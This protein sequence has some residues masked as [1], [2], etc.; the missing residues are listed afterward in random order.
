MDGRPALGGPA[1][2]GDTQGGKQS[3]DYQRSR[4][5]GGWGQPGSLEGID[6]FALLFRNIGPPVV[7]ATEHGSL[8]ALRAPRLFGVNAAV[9]RRV[10]INVPRPGPS[11]G[12]EFPRPVPVCGT[13]IR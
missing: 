1:L 3:P 13:A 10:A 11:T 2:E 4:C 5:N 9:Q 7:V 6:P 12:H 8:Q